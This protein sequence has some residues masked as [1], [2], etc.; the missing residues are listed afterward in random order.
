[1]PSGP[2]ISRPCAQCSASRVV[3]SVAGF[4]GPATHSSGWSGSA[5]RT[6]ASAAC[7]AR[8]HRANT[9]AGAARSAGP[10]PPPGRPSCPRPPRPAPRAAPGG[11]PWP[12]PPP[13]TGPGAAPRRR[14]SSPRAPEG[15]IHC[16]S[17]RPS[18]IFS[19]RSCSAARSS[20]M[21]MPRTMPH[22]VTRRYPGASATPRPP[23]RLTM[24]AASFGSDL[25]GT[26]HD[27]EF[28]PPSR[29]PVP[30][31]SWCGSAG[32]AETGE[33]VRLGAFLEAAEKH[34]KDDEDRDQQHD[35]QQAA[36]GPRSRP[37][38]AARRPNKDLYI[39]MGMPRHSAICRRAPNY[40]NR[41]G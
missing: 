11:R 29:R 33:A 32:S 41:R 22:R 26:G 2:V 6:A 17:S 30:G 10:L 36:A 12:R 40:L 34:R 19:S 8:C 4:I 23:A 18:R 5:A 31:A 35:P 21:L 16:A 25:P 7:R 24:I 37:A 15:D 13:R 27:H 39:S 20:K 1:M 3:A 14:S 9:S 38:P 28:G